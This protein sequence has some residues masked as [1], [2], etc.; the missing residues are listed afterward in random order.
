MLGHSLVVFMVSMVMSW[1]PSCLPLFSL[2]SWLY[3]W[4]RQFIHLLLL[5]IWSLR[6]WAALDFKKA[7]PSSGF[8]RLEEGLI[9]SDGL[10]TSQAAEAQY[11]MWK[12]EHCKSFCFAS[13]N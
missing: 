3:M 7:I 6:V 10:K 2:T 5:A 1:Q 8:K 4:M 9:L 11:R 12:G 13:T